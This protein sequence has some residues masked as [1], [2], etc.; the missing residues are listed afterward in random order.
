M[1]KI[2]AIMISLMMLCSLTV[3]ASAAEYNGINFDIDVTVDGEWEDYEGDG[4]W[5]YT[6]T[7]EYS[8]LCIEVY[9]EDALGYTSEEFYDLMKQSFIDEGFQYDEG[10]LYGGF[11]SFIAEI[12]TEDG[13]YCCLLTDIDGA[14][15]AVD[16][17][18]ADADEYDSLTDSIIGMTIYEFNGY[19]DSDDEEIED[20]EEEEIVDED[21]EEIVEDEEEEEDKDD[22]EEKSEDEEDKD[23]KSEDEDED[24][25]EKDNSILII[26]IVAAVAVVAVVVIVVVSK[27]KK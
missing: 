11:N 16:L 10:D 24:A 19:D 14:L 21:E 2:I 8:E 20:E 18:C 4:Y 25:E 7:S 27:K 13:S 23:E 26:V 5:E 22:K 15:V 1:K 12:E 6:F 17:T 3:S 9:T